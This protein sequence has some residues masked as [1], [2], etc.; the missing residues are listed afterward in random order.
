VGD[1]PLAL[2]EAS[3]SYGEQHALDAVSLEVGPGEVYGL[4]GP[5]GAGKTTAI[6]LLTGLRRTDRGS[7]RVFGRDPRDA[8][9]RR[10]L[11]VTPQ[12]V[13]FPSTL[14]V[15]ELVELVR[16]HYPAPLSLGEV[17]ERFGLAEVAHRQ[18]GGLSGG[19]QRRLAVALA[20][21]GAPAVVVLDEPTVG[22]DVDARHELWGVI[23][24]HAARGGS[25]LLTTHYLEEA[26]A[27]ATRIGI[28]VAGAKV[29]E[30][31]VAAIRRAAGVTTVRLATLPELDVPGVLR[32]ARNGAGATL[33]VHDAGDVVTELV[34]RGVPLAGL[35]VRPAG[36]EEAFAHLTRR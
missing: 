27:L 31:D 14:R 6:A 7:A 1:P 12:A 35:E 26:E 2:V 19:Q 33:Y 25:V 8:S 32:V 34:R 24:D 3:K 16:A 11:G 18:A 17:L 22:L 20:F 30:G 15:R 5:N 36:L 9:A 29:A 13:G 10:A 21:E 28:L 23:G 4:L